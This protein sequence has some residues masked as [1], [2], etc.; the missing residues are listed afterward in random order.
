MFESLLSYRNYR[1]FWW[2][3][4]TLLVG[5]GLYASLPGDSPEPTDSR[6]GEQQEFEYYSA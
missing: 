1:Y 3:V 2:F 5:I 6:L 4:G